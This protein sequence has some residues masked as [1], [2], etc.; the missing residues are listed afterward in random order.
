M[1]D[2]LWAQSFDLRT[3]WSSACEPM[4]RHRIAAPA[5]MIY[6]LLALGLADEVRITPFVELL[7]E[8]HE[9]EARFDGSVPWPESNVSAHLYLLKA[10]SLLPALTDSSTAHCGVEAQLAYSQ[11]W[12]KE[13]DRAGELPIVFHK[14]TYPFGGY[15]VLHAL[16]VLSCFPFAGVDPRIDDMLEIVERQ[17]TAQGY[18]RSGVV[19]PEWASWSFGQSTKPS[20]WL[21]FLVT[22]IQERIAL[23]QS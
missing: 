15:S 11:W 20:P 10:L 13:R 16:D 18:Y 9:A 23:S 7:L 17:A 19:Q 6:P 2:G 5:I 22:R 21:T 3:A 8:Q 14:L 1:V 12:M 4:W